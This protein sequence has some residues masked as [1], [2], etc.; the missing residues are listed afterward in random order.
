[1]TEAASE[2]PA[3]R[4]S[5]SPPSPR[6]DEGVLRVRIQWWIAGRVLVALLLLSGTLL[7]DSRPESLQ[8]FTARAL[9]ALVVATFVFALA[10]VLMLLRGRYLRGLAT[11]QIVSDI[12]LTTT[13]VYL[14]GGVASGFTFL[15]GI[16]TLISAIILGPR[17][18]RHAAVWSLL[19]YVTVGTGVAN[20]WLPHPPDQDASHYLLAKGEVGFAILRNMIGLSLVSL[21]ADNLSTRLRRTGG[22][23]KQVADSAATLARLNDDIVRSITAGLVTTDV[24]DR[25]RTI[26]ATGAAMLR[27][28]HDALI[29][30]PL[31]SILAG[32]EEL[33]E[34]VSGS[35]IVR[36]ETTA[37]RLDGTSFPV[38]F[39]RTPLISLDGEI[40]GGL[41]VFQDLSEVTALRETAER[42][43]RHAALGRLAASLAHEIRNPLGSIS[44]SVQIVRESELVEEDKRLLGIVV[45]EVERLDALVT[46]MLDLTKP[47]TPELANVDIAKLAREVV[48]VARRNAQNTKNVTITHTLSADDV[49]MARADGDQMRQ[50]LWNLI[51]NALQASPKN[52]N[53]TVSVQRKDT[54]EVQFEV[55]DEGPGVPAE[56]QKRM[57][58]MFYS[59]REHGLGIG[60]A[61]VKQIVDAHHGTIEI[62]NGSP[63]GAIFRVT[64]RAV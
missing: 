1:M 8:T 36:R 25:I 3:K 12:A 43:E 58:E 24:E 9:I 10:S 19:V 62:T 20:G 55:R 32:L 64:L 16:T 13:L 44:G 23:L 4:V 21:L 41:V 22:E 51:K 5:G 18:S 7:I 56:S 59:G 34:R 49:M 46:D 48:D 39:T 15:Y 30:I 52:A 6:E 57:F 50:V 63:R 28:T 17:A 38:G 42:A 14:I 2:T 31:A 53:V 35:E 61:L 27:A 45:S 47:R 33:P 60:L 11:A 37:H 29:G 26:N 40:V 54:G